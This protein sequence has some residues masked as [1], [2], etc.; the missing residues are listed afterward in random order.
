MTP[1]EI[2]TL[3]AETTT[4]DL[5]ELDESTFDGIY[6]LDCYWLNEKILIKTVAKVNI[7]HRRYI[8]VK[9]VWFN[10]KP[11]MIHLRGGRSGCDAVKSLI[12]DEK[13]YKEA[14]SYLLELILQNLKIETVDADSDCDD[15]S[16]FYNYDLKELLKRD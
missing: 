2:Y 16:V 13:T 11:F 7:D 3:P 6:L 1:N 5:L 9:T 12:T 15:L 10:D 8:S 4:C 14:H